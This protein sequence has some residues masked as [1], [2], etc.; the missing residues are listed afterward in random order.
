MQL[1]KEKVKLLEQIRSDAKLYT[2]V[3]Q[4]ESIKL[5]EI[6]MEN[7]KLKSTLGALTKLYS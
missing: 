5:N 6:A 4:E 7:K 2:S 3:L 1:K